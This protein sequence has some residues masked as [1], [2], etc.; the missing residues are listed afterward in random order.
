MMQRIANN[1]VYK[2]WTGSPKYK[3]MTE[4][5]K[6]AKRKVKEFRDMHGDPFGMT[7]EQEEQYR[8]G[9][10]VRQEDEMDELAGSLALRYYAKP[11]RSLSP[12]EQS[13]MED[14]AKR[15]MRA[16]GSMKYKFALRNQ[17]SQER[18]GAKLSLADVNKYM[19]EEA[20]RKAHMNLE[21]LE[22]RFNRAPTRVSRK[23]LS[24]KVYRA[25]DSLKRINER[26]NEAMLGN[27]GQMKNLAGDNIVV[28]NIDNQRYKR[29]DDFYSNKSTE[30]L[31]GAEVGMAQTARSQQQ[32]LRYYKDP[33][34]KEMATKKYEDA[35][36][37]LSII[38]KR[39]A[40][41]KAN[42]QELP[43]L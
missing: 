3:E 2:E 14:E 32:R 34:Q 5:K 13:R 18:G 38:K 37:R 16:R 24:R 21:I 28:P 17:L 33:R 4:K 9:L 30:D 8:R 39:I 25:E 6:T 1:E 36:A 29:Y 22:S 20:Q 23:I 12:H 27:E 41:I 40:E 11:L 35:V 15:L 10:K 7:A 26:I 31:Y 19:N 42:K 43:T